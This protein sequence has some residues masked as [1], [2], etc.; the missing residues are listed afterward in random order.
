MFTAETRQNPNDSTAH[1]MLA[2]IYCKQ[3]RK[4]E[5]I[6]EFQVALDLDKPELSLIIVVRH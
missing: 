3:Q 2:Q 5:A 6:R 1:Y 4:P